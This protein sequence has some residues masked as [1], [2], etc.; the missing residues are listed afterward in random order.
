MPR[1]WHNIHVAIILPAI[2]NDKEKSLHCNKAV[3]VAK[4]M[5]KEAAAR[6]IDVDP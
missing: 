3:K 4:N 6:Q 2:Y 5:T 1:A